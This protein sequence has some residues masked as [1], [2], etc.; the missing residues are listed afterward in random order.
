M[1]IMYIDNKPYI[2]QNSQLEYEKK[3]GLKN[4]L[5]G[6]V[7]KIINDK[8]RIRSNKYYPY[9]LQHHFDKVPKYILSYLGSHA[10]KPLL[11]QHFK[12]ICNQTM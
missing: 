5:I 1:N 12:E 8:N 4:M 6:K 3:I 11:S 2:N 10:F 7:P 9:N